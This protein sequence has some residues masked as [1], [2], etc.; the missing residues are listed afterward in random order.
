MDLYSK[1]RGFTEHNLNGKALQ[2]GG[3]VESFDAIVYV[4]IMLSLI[5]C[6]FLIL[7]THLWK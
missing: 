2:E 3:K 6:A 5:F 7:I 4:V 1:Y